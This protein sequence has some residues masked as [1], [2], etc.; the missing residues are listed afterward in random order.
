MKNVKSEKAGKRQRANGRRQGWCNKNNKSIYPLKSE[1]EALD[2]SFTLKHGKRKK[3]VTAKQW[4]SEHN[5]LYSTFRSDFTELIA[6]SG[7]SKDLRLPFAFC[8]LP[9]SKFPGKLT[10]SIMNIN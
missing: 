7:L 10:R 6:S 8:R 2:Q 3:N 9:Y 5:D 1:S 4:T